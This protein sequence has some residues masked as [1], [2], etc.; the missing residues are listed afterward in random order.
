HNYQYGIDYSF[1]GV[2]QFDSNTGIITLQDVYN[3][4][5]D[6]QLT[7]SLVQAFKSSTISELMMKSYLSGTTAKLNLGAEY[8]LLNNVLSFGL[9]FSSRFSKKTLTEEITASINARP[10][11]WLNGT[12]SYSAFNGRMSSVGAGLGIKT[13]FVHWFFAADYIPFQKVTLT[14]SDVGF[15]SQTKIAIPYNT[16]SFN[17]SAGVNFVFDCLITNVKSKKI[18]TAKKLGLRNLN[19]KVT[20]KTSTILPDLNKISKNRTR[21]GSDGLNKKTPNQD[22]HCDWK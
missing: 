15:N 11:K 4:L 14:L 7:D 10:Y 6:G 9:L 19:P 5:I 16:T 21:I 22:C 20:H 17:F 12:L 1:D 2:R 13:G 3:R 8:A 18:Q